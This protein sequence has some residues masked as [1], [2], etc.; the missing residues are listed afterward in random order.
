MESELVTEYRAAVYRT[1]AALV[2]KLLWLF[3]ALAV[4]FSLFDLR[5]L[6]LHPM[7]YWL[8]ANRA[9]SIVAF[10]ALIWKFHRC[11]TLSEYD[12]LSVA[13][14]VVTQASLLIS[15][16]IRPEYQH[17]LL[18]IL[19]IFG[20]YTLL[21]LPLMWLT[22]PI[23]AF[24]ILN[25]A[26][27]I[28]LH[29]LGTTELTLGIVM[30][31]L[32]NLVGFLS[33][34]KNLRMGEESIRLKRQLEREKREVHTQNHIN[35]TLMSLIAHDLRAPIGNLALNLEHILD[36]KSAD[37]R[38]QVLRGMVGEFKQVYVT[39]DNLL[40]WTR[41]LRGRL[42]PDPECFDV[43]TAVAEEAR[44]LASTL[45]SKDIQLTCQIPEHAT[46]R[47]DRQMFKTCVRN[48]LSNA[49]KFSPQ[50]GAVGLSIRVD[51]RGEPVELSVENSGEGIP[52]EDRTQLFQEFSPSRTPKH[53]GKGFGMGLYLCR[54]MS[55]ANG[56]GIA[57]DSVQ[58]KFTRFTIRLTPNE[59]GTE[60]SHVAA[61]RRR[62]S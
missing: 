42:E 30:T 61:E 37:T 31:G 54:L 25:I 52:E 29:R 40:M 5:L 1:D 32:A 26:N 7:A 47:W 38:E 15:S 43:A 28:F 57:C 9:A 49:G 48:L 53:P 45:R 34:R 33:A 16:L 13:L 46:L 60:L 50:G 21:H 18:D 6:G 58:G 17:Y 59:D 36:L 39:F 44:L 10:A 11:A 24:S 4:F 14:L 2:A 3:I 20:A 22:V 41:G 23:L 27:N 51:G 56:G 12:R 8:L 55:E 62:A 19:W 35:E